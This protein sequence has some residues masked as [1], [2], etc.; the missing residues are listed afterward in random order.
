MLLLVPQPRSELVEASIDAL[1]QCVSWLS[2]FRSP[3]A[4]GATAVVD[5]VGGKIDVCSSVGWFV[6]GGAYNGSGI[7]AI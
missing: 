1:T 4:C 2:G 6:G 7:G 3:H 5:A